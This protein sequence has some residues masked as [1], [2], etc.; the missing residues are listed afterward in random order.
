MHLGRV[1]TIHRHTY[2]AKLGVCLSMG[3]IIMIPSS[4]VRA[5]A[6]LDFDSSGR[7]MVQGKRKGKEKI[8]LINKIQS[9]NKIITI[10]RT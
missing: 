10:K 6:G 5:A 8:R 1:D 2:E 7:E 3:V 9:Q 4:F